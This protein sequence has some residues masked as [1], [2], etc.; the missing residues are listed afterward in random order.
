MDV[1]IQNDFGKVVSDMLA[2]SMNYRQPLINFY[3]WMIRRTQLTFSKLGKKGNT[4]P[5]REMVWKWFAIQ[6]IRKHP[7]PGQRAIVPAEGIPGEV[8]GRL[9]HGPKKNNRI[10]SSSMMMQN[11]RTM[12]KA[13]LSRFHVGNNYLIAETPVKYAKYQQ[14]MRPFAFMTQEDIEF[15]RKQILKYLTEK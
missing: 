5:F 12:F 4:T 2:K 9:R 13:A 7:K 6:Y 8:K 10:T 14:K 11:N 15:L 3:G 1:K